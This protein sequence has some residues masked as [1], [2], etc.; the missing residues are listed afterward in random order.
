MKE[1]S[2]EKM[3]LWLA[4]KIRVTKDRLQESQTLLAK[5]GVSDREARL[6]W[7]LQVQTQC[8][9]LPG[10]QTAFP[11]PPL[12]T[13]DLIAMNLQV[14]SKVMASKFVGNILT[15]REEMS[16]LSTA[17]E[18]WE[19]ALVKARRGGTEADAEALGTQLK[20][21]KKK[22]KALKQKL[23]K[24]LD[25]LA[26][27]DDASVQA[28]KKAEKNKV[29]SMQ[30]QLRVWRRRIMA[31]LTELRMESGRLERTALRSKNHGESDY[32]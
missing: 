30:L 11:F 1:Q 8:R 20:E 3:V 22:T 16:Q 10:E 17:I 15:M 14:V 25:L 13:L 27:K 29:L 23:E 12:D 31:K 28:L 6:Q 32:L 26:L 18:R 4:R 2:M 24:A 5:S 9:P 19:R 7:T 21:G